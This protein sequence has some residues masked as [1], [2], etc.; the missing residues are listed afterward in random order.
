MSVVHAYQ[1]DDGAVLACHIEKLSLDPL[2]G[3]YHAEYAAVLVRLGR[4]S[5]ARDSYLSAANLNPVLAP[6]ATR[7][8]KKIGLEHADAPSSPSVRAA[9]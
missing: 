4:V 1:K 5:D 2:D 6:Y 8:A 7:K 9:I 3:M